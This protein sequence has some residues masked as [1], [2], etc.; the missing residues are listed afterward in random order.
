MSHDRFAVAAATLRMAGLEVRDDLLSETSLKMKLEELKPKTEEEYYRMLHRPGTLLR[1]PDPCSHKAPD[2]SR[3][4]Q[5][6]KAIAKRRK[7]NKNKK[8]H[9]K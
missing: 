1:F 3:E 5:T 8:T 2:N 6:K 9:R 4:I 7:R